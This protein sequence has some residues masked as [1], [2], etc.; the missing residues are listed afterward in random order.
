MFT[1]FQKGPWGIFCRWSSPSVSA[2]APQEQIQPQYAPLPQRR[3]MS[4]IRTNVWTKQMTSHQVIGF[5]EKTFQMK[6]GQARMK[7][8]ALQYSRPWS[9]ASDFGKRLSA[10]VRPNPESKWALWPSH[11]RSRY[12]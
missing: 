8:K 1:R 12:G 5:Q 7:P 4:G 3:M 2:S 6:S 11:G 9:A 10:K